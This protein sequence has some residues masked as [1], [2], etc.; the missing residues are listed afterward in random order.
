MTSWSC[1]KFLFLV[2]FLNLAITK[3]M[4]PSLLQPIQTQKTVA[5]DR[6]PLG[7]E[8]LTTANMSR[9]CCILKHRLLLHVHV[10]IYICTI[11]NPKHIAKALNYIPTLWSRG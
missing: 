1:G 7:I 6:L 10:H 11:Y 2:T 4:F 9:L 8:L 5:I 3:Y